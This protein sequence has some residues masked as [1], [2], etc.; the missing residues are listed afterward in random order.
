MARQLAH[1]VDVRLSHMRV[2]EKALLRD[3]PPL[4]KGETPS[5]A[6]LEQALGASAAAVEAQL[7]RLVAQGEQ[8][9]KAP[10]LI[11]LGYLIAHESHHR[12]QLLL[13]LKQSGVSLSDP[14]R[15][16]IWERWF[17]P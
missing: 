16:G 3:V 15:W 12:G 8:V 6:W 14:L 7:A 5:R 2:A 4:G 11:F 17:K 1:V 9:H 10:P 13:A